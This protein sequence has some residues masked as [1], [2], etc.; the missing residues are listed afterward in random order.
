[1]SERKEWEEEERIWIMLCMKTLKWKMIDEILLR[2]GYKS[3]GNKNTK[4][5]IK[6]NPDRNVA[7]FFSHLIFY[8]T[9]RR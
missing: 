9:L 6:G 1:M 5:V 7:D 3:H 2:D 4:K 8:D